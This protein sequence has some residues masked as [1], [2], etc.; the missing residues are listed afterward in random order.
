MRISQLATLVPTTISQL[1]TL[2]PT[3]ISQLATLVPTARFAWPWRR[4]GPPRASLGAACGYPARAGVRGPGRMRGR[5][6]LSG[7]A[8]GEG[9]VRRPGRWR[10]KKNVDKR[11][12]PVSMYLLTL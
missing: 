7:A 6:R 4:E 10:A 11:Q 9:V 1:A 5:I 3:T 2:V 8:L 12:P